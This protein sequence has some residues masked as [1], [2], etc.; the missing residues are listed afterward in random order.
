MSDEL[1]YLSAVE[2]AQ[3]VHKRKLSPVEITRAA[4]AR[5][6]RVNP[7]VNAY[8]TVVAEAALEAAK[9]AEAA[10]MRGGPLG[11][12]HGVP[13]S[14]KD[15]IG[16]AGVR[17]TSGSLLFRDNVAKDDA[18]SVARLRR[19]GA[20]ILGKTN[21]PEFGW[22]GVTDNRV[23]GPTRNPWNLELTAGGSSGGASAAVAAGLGPIGLG[24]DGG[25][26][27]RIPAAFCELVG[28]KPSFGRIPNYPP[29]GVDSLR[30]SGPITRTVAD[31]ALALMVMGGP[32]ESDLN[33]LPSDSIDYLATLDD[34][35][36]GLK[37]AYSADLG[38]AQVDREVAAIVEDAA[39][40]LEASGAIVEAIN[41]RWTD[42]YDTWGTFF[43][44]GIAARLTESVT[45][46]GNQ[47]DP[48]LL[49]IV[50]RG[51][52]L[53]AVDYVNAT[54]A[55]SAFW[56]QVHPVFA[57]FDLLLTPALAVLPFPIGRD[58]PDVP[59]KSTGG[60]L[61]WS[62]FTY[63]FNLSGQPAISVPCGRSKS[64]LPVGLQIVG[65]RFAD[66][67]VLRAARAWEQ[68][69]PWAERKPP[70]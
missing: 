29:N 49:P 12:L 8:C 39:R 50:E 48:G 37:I 27:L 33:S 56:Q 23:F 67:T 16:V 58:R 35:I 41:Q 45:T 69:Q 65:R 28:F 55:R 21:T 4:L 51:L 30:H 44:G 7:K 52:K 70:L 1:A 13:V 6:E 22:K 64:G 25:G 24:T 11:P 2:L 19:A 68:I 40:H 66:A 20:I 9:A 3:L 18:I 61:R 60:E 26:S 54:L 63:P 47:L 53:T 43:Y 5:I 14:V 42:P 31:A 32:D 62:P 46:K 34:G 38:Y 10:V 15:L 59:T 36:K 57:K 17:M